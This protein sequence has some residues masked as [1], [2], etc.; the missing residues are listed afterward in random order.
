MFKLFQPGSPEEVAFK[1]AANAD[2]G[3]IFQVPGRWGVGSARRYLV[4]E[5]QK[6]EIMRRLARNRRDGFI[7][8]FILAAILVPIGM[9]YADVLDQWISGPM[10]IVLAGVVWGFIL[11]AYNAAR[12]RPVLIGLPTTDQRI[13]F[14][15]RIRTQARTMSYQQT[16]IPGLV[17]LL[18]GLASLHELVAIDATGLHVRPGPDPTVPLI[19]MVVLTSLGTYLLVIA[20]IRRRLARPAG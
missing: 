2:D 11:L 17:F 7:L 9:Q 6:T 13:T 5:Q 15:D 19:G 10:A 8:I 1:R 14:A 4:G 16:I 20:A 18:I 12:L 3:W